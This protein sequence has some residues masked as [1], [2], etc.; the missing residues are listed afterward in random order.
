MTLRLSF[1]AV[2]QLKLDNTSQFWRPRAESGLVHKA[3]QWTE[4]LILILNKQ[5]F[6][7]GMVGGGGG[8]EGGD[9]VSLC[10]SCLDGPIH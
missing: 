4:N 6:G 2:Q 8:V 3:I 1:T 9:S 5:G 10:N 7:I